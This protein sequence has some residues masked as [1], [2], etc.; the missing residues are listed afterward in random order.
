MLFYNLIITLLFVFLRPYFLIQLI[1]KNRE[2]KW[3]LG[4]AK[5]PYTKRKRI[6]IHASSVGEINGISSLINR[7]VKAH[8]ECLIYLSTMTLTGQERAKQI[9]LNHPRNIFP[10]LFPLDVPL[11]MMMVLSKIKPKLLILTETEIWPVLIFYAK[12]M[13]CKILLINA[14]LSEKSVRNYN[15]L[16]VIFNETISKIDFISAQSEIDKD[17]FSEFET[18]NI[19]VN[20]NLKFALSLPDFENNQIR[21]GWNIKSDLVITF[22]SSRPGEEEL[23][24]EL[25]KYLI[26]QGIKHQII[27][28]P[29]HLNR[30]PEIE[31]ILKNYNIKYEKL[32]EV[33]DE[34][35]ILLID[36]MGELTKA[37]SISD[38]A[39]IGGSF[40][41]FG[42]HNPLEAAYFGKPILMGKFHISCRKTVEI[43]MKYNAIEIVDKEEL[44]QK[45]LDLYKHPEIR[46]RMG[47][48]AKIVMK[49]NK[50]SLNKTLDLIEKYL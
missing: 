21:N 15:K 35:D 17:R 18:K 5:F 27:I 34:C 11:I 16:K 9:A 33:K 28:A 29:R 24:A 22:G 6:W 38:I 23:V 46:K 44:N 3:R 32:S 47:Y 8:P 7:F 31:K 10:F 2:W 14:R 12:K 50:E 4:L 26:S 39:I 30:L 20:G 36:K 13:S 45:V 40:Y 37:Y 43:L 42:G 19:E 25:H 48:S 1:A 49:D 41:D